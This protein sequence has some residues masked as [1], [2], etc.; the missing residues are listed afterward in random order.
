MKKYEQF[1]NI[2]DDVKILH[3]K[4][5]YQY[6]DDDNELSNFEGTANLCKRFYKENITNLPL[7]QAMVFMSKQIDAVYHMVGE[8]KVNTI[9]TLEDKFKDIIAYSAL[10]ILL[11]R[12]YQYD[13]VYPKDEII[14]MT[15]PTKCD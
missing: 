4:K 15:E 2:L 13:K 10:C 5:N 3:E 12:G 6:A 7:L 1:N 9:E 14:G 11:S 8:G